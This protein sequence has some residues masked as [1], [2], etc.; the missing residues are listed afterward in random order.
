MKSNAL[1]TR[2]YN[3]FISSTFRDMDFERDLI[4]YKII[5]MLNEHFR[6]RFIEIQAIDLRMGVNTEKMSEEDSARKVLNVCA[7]SIDEARPFFIGLIGARYGWV[8]PVERWQ[9]FISHL[10][11]EDQALMQDT[12]GKSVTELE[13]VYGALTPKSLQESHTLFFMRDEASYKGIPEDILSE[14][15]DVDPEQEKKLKDLKER[16][17]RDMKGFGGHDDKVIG[18]HIDWDPEHEGFDEQSEDFSA[19]VLD[20]LKTQIES[21]LETAEEMSWWEEEKVIAENTLQQKLRDICTT[22]PN[23]DEL[24][25]QKIYEG[26]VGNGKTTLLAW[27]WDRRRKETDDICLVACVGKT[28]Y[29][30]AMYYIMAR[31]CEELAIALGEKSKGAGYMAE[32]KPFV[33]ICDEFYRL[34]GIAYDKGF[35]ISVFMDD[36]DVFRHTNPAD[37]FLGCIDSRVNL[38]ATCETEEAVKVQ[39]YHSYCE[40]GYTDFIKGKPL[41]DLVRINERRFHIELPGDIRKKLLKRGHMA[42]SIPTLF[43]MIAM[44]NGASFDEL[45]S[46]EGDFNKNFAK[47]FMDIFDANFMSGDDEYMLPAELAYHICGMIG[48]DADWYQMM[49]GYLSLCPGGLR[50]SDLEALAEDDWDALE[51]AQ[52]AYYLQDY[53]GVDSAGL[54]RTSFEGFGYDFE[55][56]E[57]EADLEEYA[58]TLPEGDWIR[59]RILSIPMIQP[60]EHL[61]ELDQKAVDRAGDNYFGSN[62]SPADK[63]AVRK[64]VDKMKGYTDYDTFNPVDKGGLKKNPFATFTEQSITLR[65]NG[66]LV[67]ELAFFGM[68]LKEILQDAWDNIKDSPVSEELYIE[69]LTLQLLNIYGAAVDL[70]NDRKLSKKLDIDKIYELQDYAQYGYV[71]CFIRLCHLR[72]LNRIFAEIS[73]FVDAYESE[74]PIETDTT[75]IFRTLKIIV[76][77]ILELIN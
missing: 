51:W 60:A 47:V 43:K 21:E 1:R 30:S 57:L 28:P 76:D 68:M 14:F 59:D 32:D 9:E 19:I 7:S 36:V 41:E 37:L 74:E 31:W 53:I 12:F 42:G 62:G 39:A 67:E 20:H 45:R 61:Y 48:L 18:Y 55:E 11:E 56:G 73:P 35:Q 25:K 6:D 15:C 34:V 69:N 71:I 4:K 8:P 3:I 40:P 75:S 58:E 38:V 52:L 63:K 17:V 70:E 72:P 44:T 29:S 65:K 50:T 49:L 46:Q 24:A 26:I 10:P 2:R 66:M 23:Y 5:P 22:L 77:I 33:Y 27:Q 13:I 16:I 54:W 64:F